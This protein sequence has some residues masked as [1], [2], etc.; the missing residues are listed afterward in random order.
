M[1]QKNILEGCSKTE[2]TCKDTEIELF[3]SRIEL[4]FLLTNATGLRHETL[5][6]AFVF[7]SESG[8]QF[9]EFNWNVET[10]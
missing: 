5:T 2:L 8:R 3:D 7:P 10:S 1:L 9:L 6:Q 4:S